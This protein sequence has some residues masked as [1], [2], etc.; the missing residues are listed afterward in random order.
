MYKGVSK[1]SWKKIVQLRWA[2]F[3]YSVKN[4]EQ[5]IEHDIDRVM[6]FAY[7]IYS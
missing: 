4:V 3:T 5:R 1:H 2:V 7:I 6:E